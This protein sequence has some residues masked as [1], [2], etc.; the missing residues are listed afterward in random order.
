MGT[1]A[2]DTVILSVNKDP[3]IA[4]FNLQNHLNQTNELYRLS[5]SRFSTKLLRIEGAMWSA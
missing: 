4:T 1:F 3:A 2:D 5:D